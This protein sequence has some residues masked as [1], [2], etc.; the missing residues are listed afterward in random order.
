MLE[1]GG[2]R[3]PEDVV[4]Q[5]VSGLDEIKRTLKEISSCLAQITTQI[6]LHE[7]RIETLEREQKE[8]RAE[9]RT[10]TAEIRSIH[11]TCI[12]REDVWRRGKD[13][14]DSGESDPQS[15]WNRMVANGVMVVLGAAAGGIVAA[16]IGR[17]F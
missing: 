4:A 13:K 8:S 11:E 12:M 9:Q 5:L 7:R 14:L 1:E 10:M 2:V 17:I 16:V 15:W 6:A 3:M